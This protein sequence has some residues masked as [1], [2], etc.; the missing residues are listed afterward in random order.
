M[1][2]KRSSG[3]SL[4]NTTNPDAVL[5]QVGK[6]WIL[7]WDGKSILTT[8]SRTNNSEFLPVGKISSFSLPGYPTFNF[9]VINNH[10]EDH[11]SNDN[12][13]SSC[14]KE[15][16]TSFTE[17][18]SVKE[19]EQSQMSEPFSPF[20][21]QMSIQELTSS[22]PRHRL[23]F[24]DASLS[25]SRRSNAKNMFRLRLLENQ[26]NSNVLVPEKYLQQHDRSA[27]R[28]LRAERYVREDYE[29]FEMNDISERAY[30]EAVM[31]TKTLLDIAIHEHERSKQD[32]L[33]RNGEVRVLQDRLANVVHLLDDIQRRNNSSDA[34][35]QDLTRL[36][37]RNKALEESIERYRRK[38]ERLELENKLFLQARQ[39]VKLEKDKNLSLS[40]TILQLERDV[41]GK[42]AEIQRL[43][44]SLDMAKR[45]Y[46][47]Q[48]TPLSTIVT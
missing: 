1:G 11:P 5:K 34:L 29:Q 38:C 46:A 41:A 23:S 25:V 42:Q 28:D 24:S 4:I 21:P 10:I 19:E 30:C 12:L 2:K 7:Q 31:T 47:R 20:S 27:I 26:A 43:E 22:E 3:M 39:E 48:I 15:K 6:S 33:I 18:V 37:Q 16:F 17:S 32:L 44:H 13:S 36:T 14:K 40:R 45:E 35:F 8:T 9:D